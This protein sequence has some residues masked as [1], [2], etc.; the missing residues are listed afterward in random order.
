MVSAQEGYQRFSEKE[1]YQNQITRE[2]N[3]NTEYITIKP[4]GKK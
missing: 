2:N 3:R 4:K 1:N